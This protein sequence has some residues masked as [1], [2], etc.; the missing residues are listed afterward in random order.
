MR[1]R[2]G[3]LCWGVRV[4][5]GTGLWPCAGRLSRTLRTSKR[6]TS[7]VCSEQTGFVL[8]RLVTVAGLVAVW[9]AILGQWDN[10]PMIPDVCAVVSAALGRLGLGLGSLLPSTA[11]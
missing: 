10:V 11:L 6:E 7:P 4:A 3:C 8:A 1:P 5:C 9:N 2:I